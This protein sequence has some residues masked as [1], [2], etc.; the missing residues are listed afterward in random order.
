VLPS[1]FSQATR[2]HERHL[3]E[4]MQELEG[5]LQRLKD[6]P[7][8]ASIAGAATPA[9]MTAPRSTTAEEAGMSDD[10][11]NEIALVC[12]D[13][14]RETGGVGGAGGA[15]TATGNA[16]T[17]AAAV[18]TVHPTATSARHGAAASHAPAVSM[19]ALRDR[20]PASAPLDKW[21]KAL[22]GRSGRT[23]FSSNVPASVSVDEV[24]DEVVEDVD[25]DDDDDDDDDEWTDAQQP[26]KHVRFSDVA[27]VNK[28]RARSLLAVGGVG[29]P[30]ITL[31]PY[32][33]SVCLFLSLLSSPLFSSRCP[34][35]FRSRSPAVSWT[36]MV[37]TRRGLHCSHT[38]ASRCRH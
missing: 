23:L 17:A 20:V 10:F 26:E 35:H 14:I 6:M 19:S 24:V 16:G 21:E 2:Q 30:K 22:Q 15:G 5:E 31:S 32:V 36:R 11:L 34:A 12:D 8:R 33:L 27:P 18:D 13:I 9:K 1:L 29:V 38:R 4:R 25:D 3:R 7:R 37:W 28:V